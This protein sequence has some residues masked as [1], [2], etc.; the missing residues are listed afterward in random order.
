VIT[1]TNNF[2]A[3]L[4]TIIIAGFPPTVATSQ[5][6]TQEW[7]EIA[8]T[9][10]VIL[11]MD[12]GSRRQRQNNPTG[13]ILTYNA[14]QETVRGKAVG[15]RVQLYESNCSEDSIGLQ[16]DIAYGRNGNV[17]DTYESGFVTA[18]PVVP[19]SL[20]E[21]I[22]NAICL[23]DPKLIGPSEAQVAQRLSQRKLINSDGTAL[24]PNGAWAM[25]T[26][27]QFYQVVNNMWAATERPTLSDAAVSVPLGLMRVSKAGKRIQF[28]STG[29]V[30]DEVQRRPVPVSELEPDGF[31]WTEGRGVQKSFIIEG[32]RYFNHIHP[33]DRGFE[34]GDVERFG[35]FLGEFNGIRFVPLT[36]VFADVSSALSSAR[37]TM[38]TVTR[39]A[40]KQRKR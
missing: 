30:Y 11:F 12:L 22:L 8:S 9:S 39:P 17:V 36:G 4:A 34:R 35:E 21:S 31:A 15:Y 10:D 28:T 23:R 1:R 6:N 20:G 18:R 5:R 38:P 40:Q 26:N 27:G 7:V 19:G 29:W 32:G 37:R 13:W 25:S 16:S 14:G 2:K 33:S 3:A 24:F